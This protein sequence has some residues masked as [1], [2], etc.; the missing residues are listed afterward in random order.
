MHDVLTEGKGFNATIA[1]ISLGFRRIHLESQSV[2][3]M[4]EENFEV[5]NLGVGKHN[6][7][8][9]KVRAWLRSGH[10]DREGS[11]IDGLI[12]K[13]DLLEASA[14]ISSLRVLGADLSGENGEEHAK[15]GW[16]G[17]G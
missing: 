9:A 4:E 15:A 16:R 6:H 2:S 3:S 11:L 14:H 12:L 17:F 1:D 13:S 7:V 10:I 8:F 5:L